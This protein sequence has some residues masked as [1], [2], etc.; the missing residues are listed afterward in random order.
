M[1]IL[2]AIKFA[3]IFHDRQEK[4]PWH[5]Q[6]WQERL[7]Q[8]IIQMLEVLFIKLWSLYRNKFDN[9]NEL[10]KYIVNTSGL[11]RYIKN[12]ITFS[13]LIKWCISLWLYRQLNISNNFI[14]SLVK[15]IKLEM[16]TLLIPFYEGNITLLLKMWQK[17]V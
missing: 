3:V 16:Q 6:F 8:H 4:N 10:C 15:N 5:T 14:Q 1:F 17:A 2:N 7:P 13:T 9:L 11:G 12:E